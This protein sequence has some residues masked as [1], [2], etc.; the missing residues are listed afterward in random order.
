MPSAACRCSARALRRGRRWR[1]AAGAGAAARAHARRRGRRA[2]R[3]PSPPRPLLWKVSDAD[4]DI[5]LLGSFHALKPSDYPL[6]ASVDAA[7][8]DAEVVAFEVSPEEMTSPELG[9]PMMQRRACDPEGGSLQAALD[10]G[11]LAAA[12]GVRA[13]ARPADRASA[14][15]SSPGSSALVIRWR[16]MGRVGYDPAQGLDQQLIAR[17]AAARQ[18][19]ARAGNRR[20]PDR[21]AGRH[22]RDRAAAVAGGGARRCRGLQRAHGRTARAV[23]QRRRRRRSRRKLTEE[24]RAATRS[25]TSASTSTATRPGCRSCARCS[26]PKPS[27]DTL[28]VVGTMHLLGPGRRWSASCASQ[29]Y[30]VERL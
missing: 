18:A 28:V 26:T 5:Y 1:R 23:A 10:A 16:E 12:A 4:N 7:F 22:E 11:D 14:G 9:M 13:V 21:G 17:A 15:A 27:D 25:C 30:R 3:R 24:F 29:G 19:H 8:A 20:Q 2:G 6:A